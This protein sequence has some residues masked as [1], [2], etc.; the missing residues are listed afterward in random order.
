MILH[1]GDI[2]TIIRVTIKDGGTAVDVSSSSSVVFTAHPPQGSAKSW[3][4]SHNSDGSDGVEDYTTLTGD[5]DTAGEWQIQA[6]VTFSGTKVIRSI[7]KTVTV[8]PR[9]DSA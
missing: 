1:N 5:I 2:G 6:L 9:L 3:T 8:G 7:P 4:A